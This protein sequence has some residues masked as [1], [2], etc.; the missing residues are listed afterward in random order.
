[1][2]PLMLQAEAVLQLRK[3]QA[4]A[5]EAA[6]STPRLA[7]A[8]FVRQ[9][10]SVIDPEPYVHGWHIDV[11]CEHLEA[12]SRREIRD[13]L[14][15]VPPRSSKSLITSVCWHPWVWTW[16]PSARFIYASYSGALSL[17]HALLARDLIGSQWYQDTFKPRWTLRQE[18]RGKGL[19]T[20]TAK[21]FRFST[22]VGSMAT[23][24]GAT[25]RIADDIHKISEGESETR[26]ELIAA[27]NFWQKTMPSRVTNPK[28]SCSVVVGQRVAEDDLS[29]ELLKEGA[30]QYLVIPMEYEAP[31]PGVPQSQT[32]LAWVDPR[33]EPGELMC[34]GRYG[35]AEIA[36][37]KL[38][39]G[40]D[41][42]AQYQQR[43]TSDSTT[44]FKRS[45]WMRYDVMPD[46]DWFEIIIQSWDMAVKDEETS[47]YYAGHVWGV[48]EGTHGLQLVLLDRVW[49]RMDF[50]EGIEAVK[51]MSAKWPKA[52]GKLIEDKA[53][54][55]PTMRML[56]G[57]IFGLIPID[58]GS[59]GNKYA[60]AKAIAYLQRGK[61]CWVPADSLRSW[62]SEYIENMA[63][64]QWDDVDATSQAWSNLAMPSPALDK[65]REEA[66]KKHV[67]QHKIREAQ[68]REK[69]G[70]SFSHV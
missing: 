57:Q 15:N 50:P 38:R 22:S 48:R 31:G 54:G 45:D 25:F 29:G 12:V 47:S 51:T 33:T 62:G 16:W 6:Q 60:R 2:T 36:P 4:A 56:R 10:W 68:R 21:G 13:L 55:T 52:Y 34:E 3:R 69:R 67:L 37:L 61:Q 58:P 23:G 42:Y 64:L 49:Q 30:Y 20:N 40:F 26:A 11:I 46:P 65:V 59:Q 7:L 44:L 28:E 39:L 5:Q 32:A 9:A 41:W 24:M 27:K 1:M 8:A 14:I 70:V 19:Y 18:E 53:N 43:P 17:V 63:T 35:E 66:M